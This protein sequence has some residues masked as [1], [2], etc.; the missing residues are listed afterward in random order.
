[1]EFYLHIF[2]YLSIKKEGS[3][4]M[5]VSCNINLHTTR[6]SVW[7]GTRAQNTLSFYLSQ[8]YV[9]THTPKT[10]HGFLNF[11]CKGCEGTA[12]LGSL[13]KAWGML[14]PRPLRQWGT[15][16]RCCVHQFKTVRSDTKPGSVAAC[17]DAHGQGCHCSS[18]PHH[19]LWV[20]PDKTNCGT[21]LLYFTK[22]AG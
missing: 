11:T 8:L 20:V 13:E 14:S 7:M 15:Y 18:C 2:L 12:P 1:M 19:H 16:H 3:R 10:L 9:C 4:Q 17:N 6:T 5:T 21:P 22:T